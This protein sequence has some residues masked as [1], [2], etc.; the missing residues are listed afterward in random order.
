LYFSSH[1]LSLANTANYAAS[2]LEFLTI[3]LETM[4][5][6]PMNAKAKILSITF[7]Y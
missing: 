1:F 5:N 4:R 3:V 7:F 2:C 6:W